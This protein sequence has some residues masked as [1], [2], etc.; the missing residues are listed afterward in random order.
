MSDLFD[1]DTLVAGT[2]LIN[3]MT[4]E[5]KKIWE[6]VITSTNMTHNG[7]KGGK[8]TKKLSSY[9]ISSTTSCLVTANI[10]SMYN[11]P[12]CHMLPS[13]YYKKNIRKV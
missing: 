6:D 2:T 3:R 5:R 7:R 13:S 11:K 1:D 9:P 8:T 10:G 12:R 4:D